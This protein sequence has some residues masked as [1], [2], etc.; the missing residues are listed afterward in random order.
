MPLSIA[1]RAAFSP[2]IWAAHGVLLRE[3]LKPEP[4]AMAQETTLPLGSVRV[5]RVLLK[6]LL[7]NALPRGMDF[8]SRRRPR[9]AP[10]PFF[11]SA[12]GRPTSYFFPARRLPATVLRA[13]RLL[14]ALVRVRWPWTGRLRRWRW[15]R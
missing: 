13:P 15:P 9:R 14:R 8:R 4:P 6:V 1:A 7:M 2:A 3:P 11:A 12:I 10:A 5:T